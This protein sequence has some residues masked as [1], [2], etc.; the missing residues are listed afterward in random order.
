MDLRLERAK[1]E[2]FG[3]E[4]FYTMSCLEDFVRK[5]DSP[6]SLMTCG[7][8]FQAFICDALDALFP[9]GTGGIEEARE[10]LTELRAAMEVVLAGEGRLYDAERAFR[11]AWE[12]LPIIPREE[13]G[14]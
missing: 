2:T 6:G 4:L 3:R 7:G 1:T 10:R 12:S 14:N 8:R 5:S 9:E 11:F 13:P